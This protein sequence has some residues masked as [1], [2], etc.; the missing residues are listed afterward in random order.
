V[1]ESRKLDPATPD[2]FDG[3]IFSAAAALDKGLIDEIG[4]WNDALAQTAQLLDT[5][6]L[7]VI[8]YEPKRTFIEQLFEGKSPVSLPSLKLQPPRFLY[9]WK[10]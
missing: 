4:Y 5:G 10:P 1:A 8:R 6:A 7:Y 3:R 2:L 9:L